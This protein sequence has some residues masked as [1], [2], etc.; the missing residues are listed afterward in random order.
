MQLIGRF[1]RSPA[2]VAAGDRDFAEEWSARER[3][4]FI[5]AAL[6]SVARVGTRKSVRM[7]AFLENAAVAVALLAMVVLPLAEIVLRKAGTTGIAGGSTILQHLVLFV[8][9]VGWCGCGA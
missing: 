9:D 7:V 5:S 1:V 2:L 4:T 8:G 3:R 6:R